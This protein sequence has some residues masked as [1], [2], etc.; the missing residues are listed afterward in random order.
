MDRLVALAAAYAPQ[1]R[2]LH[3]TGDHHLAALAPYLA[4]FANLTTLELVFCEVRPTAD[5]IDALSWPAP[6]FQ[7]TRLDVQF[8][9]CE[10]HPGL[11]EF[12]WLTRASRASLRHLVVDCGGAGLVARLLEWG[13]HLRTLHVLLK[14]WDGGG[15]LAAG[16]VEER[17]AE[18]AQL[19][20]LDGLD[21]ALLS[22]F[23][24]RSAFG[25]DAEALEAQVLQAVDRVHAEGGKEVASVEWHLC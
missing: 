12:D 25:A 14:S 3:V 11:A 19:I 1:L 8:D 18:V 13:H 21:E 6:A 15:A 24:D 16:A 22:F 7:L 4:A 23:V 10:P 2:H 20:R 17:F 5:G 9:A